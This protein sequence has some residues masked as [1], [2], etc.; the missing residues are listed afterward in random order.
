MSDTKKYQ[1]NKNRQKPVSKPGIIE[2]WS[3]RG[4]RGDR[5]SWATAAR[6]IFL[7]SFTFWII[8]AWLIWRFF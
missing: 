3:S 7:F 4:R 8:I 5:L 1:S 2:S 6:F